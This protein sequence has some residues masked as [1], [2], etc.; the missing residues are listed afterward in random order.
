MPPHDFDLSTLSWWAMVAPRQLPSRIL[1][2]S[3]L[4]RRLHINYS[5]SGA[6]QDQSNSPPKKN[7]HNTH[8]IMGNYEWVATF[9]LIICFLGASFMLR[10]QWVVKGLLNSKPLHHRSFIWNHNESG[11]ACVLVQ[12]VE[13]ESWPECYAS[14]RISIQMHQLRN[15]EKCG[16]E[17][18]GILR[19]HSGTVFR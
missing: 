15:L 8:L 9:S 16:E 19:E 2:H 12:V 17:N 3:Y 4:R 6:S 11:Q 14:V 7:K 18:S 5:L 1:R 10:C 13:Q